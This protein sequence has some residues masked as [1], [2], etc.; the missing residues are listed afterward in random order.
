MPVS[1]L[2]LII[3]LLLVGI[4]SL[5]AINGSKEG[6]NTALTI[7]IGVAV[8]IFVMPFEMLL[9]S[10]PILVFAIPML[11][12]I[13]SRKREARIASCVSISFVAVF[14]LWVYVPG[15]LL[16]VKAYQGDAK[17]Q[18]KLAKW[19]ET[20][21]FQIEPVIIWPFPPDLLGGY[22]WLEKAARQDYPP[23]LYAVGVRLKY[24][25]F[26]PM[27]KDWH[28]PSGNVFAQPERGQPYIDKAIALGYKPQ[29]A[30]STFYDNIYTT[31]D[32]RDKYE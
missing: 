3:P 23:A 18:Y 13:V 9:W 21:Q 4:P 25:N 30:E 27:P 7:L 19:T 14:F 12:A 16:M 5:F 29:V 24:G 6:A 26:V 17:S 8:L 15:W 10:V 1:Y 20:H 28:G 11:I 32:G 22:A 2:P 31:T